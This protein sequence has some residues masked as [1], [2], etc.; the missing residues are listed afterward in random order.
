MGEGG[1]GGKGKGIKGNRLRETGQPWKNGQP[2]ETESFMF[3]VYGVKS[4][5]IIGDE[6]NNGRRLSLVDW[7]EHSPSLCSTN[8]LIAY[9]QV[10]T[11]AVNR[12]LDVFNL[13]ITSVRGKAD[14]ILAPEMSHFSMKQRRLAAW[15]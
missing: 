8:C 10:I 13:K 7:V 15:K 5:L 6:L 9:L 4:Y 1:P 11:I 2:W 3:L 14:R 12:E